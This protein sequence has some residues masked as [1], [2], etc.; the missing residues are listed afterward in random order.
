MLTLLI[1]ASTS[2]VICC[3]C[4][5]VEYRCI[6]VVTSTHAA[7]KQKTIVC[8]NM[9]HST[10]TQSYD[11]PC[12]TQIHSLIDTAHIA[13]YMPRLINS[14]QHT[15]HV[16]KTK[17]N[18]HKHTYQMDL[19]KITAFRTHLASKVRVGFQVQTHRNRLNQTS[20]KV[21]NLRAKCCA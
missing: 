13:Q 11:S 2:V 14:E 5:L 6:T 19:T 17:Q 4:P 10:N 3:E 8:L 18:K 16:R 1:D 15:G 9:F 21:E 12:T 20:P 7:N